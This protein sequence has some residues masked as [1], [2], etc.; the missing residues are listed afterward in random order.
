MTLLLAPAIWDN[1]YAQV[2]I[3]NP[4]LFYHSQIDWWGELLG[5]QISLPISTHEIFQI[6]HWAEFLLH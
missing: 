5:A 3:T 6:M 1:C 4:H 2:D